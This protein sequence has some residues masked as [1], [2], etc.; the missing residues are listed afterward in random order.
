MSMPHPPPP[1]G[2]SATPGPRGRSR[3]PA[4]SLRLWRSSPSGSVSGPF[5]SPAAHFRPA[6]ACP[7]SACSRSPSSSPRPSSPPG[8]DAAAALRRRHRL[9]RS[10]ERRA[11]RQDVRG[12]GRRG[13]S[14]RRPGI[15]EALRA[16]LGQ[17]ARRSRR[18]WPRRSGPRCAARR[19][20]DFVIIA[21][22]DARGVNG[23]DDA[24]ARAKLYL[25]AGA[26]A[27]FPEALRI[28]RRVRAVRE[29][30]PRP[31]PGEHDRVRQ[32]PAARREAHSASWATG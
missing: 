17:V 31:A 8:H 32:E 16:P 5:T 28:R 6:T 14:P 30:R 29:G 25:E 27:I 7:T 3:C 21:R 12:R 11:H 9:R 18:R 13:D 15:A 2:D 10:A 26:D 19:D 24:V 4:P 22:T 1:V 20:P 23:F